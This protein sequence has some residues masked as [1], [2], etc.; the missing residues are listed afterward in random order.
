[1][2]TGKFF[3]S[4]AHADSEFVLKLAKDLRSIGTNLWLDQL[5]IPGGARWDDVVE[6]ALHASPCLLV[7]L[8]PASV[9]SNNV[10]DE[11]SFGIENGKTILP[12]LYKNCD[13][14]FRLKRLQYIDFRV[15]YNDGFKRL[16]QA[17]KPV[18]QLPTPP[19]VKDIPE[20]R[21]PSESEGGKRE[22]AVVDDSL[23]AINLTKNLT[24]IDRVQRTLDAS[25]FPPKQLYEHLVSTDLKE[26]IDI[27]SIR[28]LV[29]DDEPFLVELMR[30]LFAKGG[31]A[32]TTAGNSDEALTNQ[33][34]V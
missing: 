1:M 2:E 9:A 33:S 7:V 22:E 19:S 32:A 12:I 31:A 34:L 28:I 27:S 17:L 14:P 25:I 8:S 23:K 20:T 15:G 18:D 13:I 3:F 29:V 21:G 26:D 10:K 16:V 4:Y 11:I 30:E 6:E 24:N 5:D